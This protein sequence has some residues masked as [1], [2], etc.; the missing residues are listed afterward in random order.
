VKAARVHVKRRIATRNE[1][2][3]IVE[4]S[5]GTNRQTHRFMD[6]QQASEFVLGVRAY[7]RLVGEGV[8]ED[9]V[10]S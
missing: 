10:S 5:S 1:Y 6:Y 3:F 8:D 2:P 7:G 9:E 4:L